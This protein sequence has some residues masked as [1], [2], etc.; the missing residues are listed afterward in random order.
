[1]NLFKDIIP[2]IT[3]TGEEV[4]KSEEDFK[5]YVP[6]VVNKALSHYIDCVLYANQMNMYHSAEKEF[7]YNYLRGTVKKYKRQYSPWAKKDEIKNLDIIKK[8]YGY[9][10]QKAISALNILSD[11]DIQEIKD[12]MDTGGN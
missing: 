11:D 3:T 8:Y 12:R 10:N 5:H 4:L 7:Q 6:F 2:S 9:S 1:M